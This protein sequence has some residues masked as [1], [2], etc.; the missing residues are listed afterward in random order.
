MIGCLAFC[1]LET[2]LNAWLVAITV[3]GNS[4]TGGKVTCT[5]ADAIYNE[6]NIN[7]CQ[8]MTH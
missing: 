3:I 7:V 5:I 2:I 8:R 1:E 6:S 4:C